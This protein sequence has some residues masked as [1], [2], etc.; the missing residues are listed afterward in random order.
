MCI[1]DRINVGAN[2]MGGHV[3]V[4]IEDSI[5]YS[6]PDKKLAT[7]KSLVERI[8]RLAHELGRDIATPDEA[9]AILGLSK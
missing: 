5:Y 2:L 6:Y 1:R 4:G 9:R 3:R 8:V 7:N